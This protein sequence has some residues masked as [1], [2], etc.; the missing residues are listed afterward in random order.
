MLLELC[1]Q[2]NAER[3]MKPFL[4]TLAAEACVVFAYSPLLHY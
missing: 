3:F 2:Y 1:N 4:A